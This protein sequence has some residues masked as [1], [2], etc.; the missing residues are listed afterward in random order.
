VWRV[1]VVRCVLALA[2][3]G[4]VGCSRSRPSDSA[5]SEPPQSA[6]SLRLIALT[7]LA[8]VVE[9]C[10][11]SAR[12]RGGLDRIA[13]ELGRARAEGVPTL[14]VAVGHTLFDASRAHGGALPRQERWEAEAIASLLGALRADAVV[15]SPLDVAL[16]GSDLAL[17][18]QRL[19]SALLLAERDDKDGRFSSM[20]I[21]QRGR[22]KVALLR[23]PSTPE[24]P[25]V[26]AGLR[27]GAALRRAAAAARAAGAELVIALAAGDER[28]VTQPVHAKGA[29]ALVIGGE[30]RE[31]PRALSAGDGGVVLQ[32]GR[33]GE[34]LMVADFWL[35]KPG[36]PFALGRPA[37]SGGGGGNWI[38]TT[39]VALER[40]GPRDASTAA[41]LAKLTRKINAYNASAFRDS[42]PAA[43][44]GQASYA[45]SQPCAACHTA[46]YL[47]WRDTGHARA[48]ATLQR[49]DKEYNLDCV[50]CHVTG[51]GKPG[52]ASV[53]RV[54]GLAGVGCESCHGA[55]GGHVENPRDAARPTTAVAASICRSCHD[56]GHSPDFDERSYRLELKAPGHGMAVS[57]SP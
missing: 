12:S 32:A 2:L 36:A 56:R 17:L 19:G 45:G 9:P 51:Y 49:A 38:A 35:K 30:L 52:G 26:D 46:A 13:A 48:Y 21:V 41:A 20:R 44:S 4:G 15:P 11:C 1:R 57:R 25:A 47:W 31:Q 24:Q 10:G 34:F 54:E 3:I 37:R 40:D 5:S 50:G 14:F 28:P 39:S 27:E 33:A 43:A 7:D 42:E 16:A 18:G 53:G 29:D 22:T 55:A 8:G 23:A 6:P